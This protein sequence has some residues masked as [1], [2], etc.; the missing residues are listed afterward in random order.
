MNDTNLGNYLILCC[1]T[2][3]TGHTRYASYKDALEAAIAY[4]EL[5]GEEYC[6]VRI[7]AYVEAPTLRC[8]VHELW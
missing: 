2:N 8:T 6:I 5:R 3:F 1:S 4:S 7:E